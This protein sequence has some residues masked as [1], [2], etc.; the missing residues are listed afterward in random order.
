MYLKALLVDIKPLMILHGIE[1]IHHCKI[2]I[3]HKTWFLYRLYDI[4]ID[5]LT[6]KF[7]LIR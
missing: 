7:I 6:K 3:Q 4:A 1:Q 5:S 2:T